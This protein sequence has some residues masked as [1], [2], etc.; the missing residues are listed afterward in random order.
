MGRRNSTK[1]EMDGGVW[2]IDNRC[3][4]KCLMEEEGMGRTGGEEEGVGRTGGDDDDNNNNNNVL[5]GD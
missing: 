1:A 4:W 5:W 2:L 3:K